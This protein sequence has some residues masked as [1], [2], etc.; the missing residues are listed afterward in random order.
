LL[1]TGFREWSKS[2]FNSF[3]TACDK[4]GRHSYE[5]IATTINKT[6]DAVIS[7]SNVFWS[8]LSEL[9]DFEK[10][11]KQIEGGETKLE[12]KKQQLELLEWKKAA[13]PVIDFNPNIYTKFKSKLYSI[14]ADKFLA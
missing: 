8:R 10:V 4:W 11:L 7:Y 2:D 12:N 6:V 13:Y 14:D 5:E 1:A 9:S 3:I